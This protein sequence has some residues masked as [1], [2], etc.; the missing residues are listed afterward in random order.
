M[1]ERSRDEEVGDEGISGGEGVGVLMQKRRRRQQHTDHDSN[2][3]SVCE[4]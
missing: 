4:A 3:H 1:A 2:T